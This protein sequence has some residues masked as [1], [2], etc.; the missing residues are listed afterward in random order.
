MKSDSL[1]VSVFI[2]T[3]S[4]AQAIELNKR[5][6]MGGSRPASSM[7]VQNATLKLDG[8]AW[9]TDNFYH[10]KEDEYRADTP[11]GY[12]HSIVYSGEPLNNSQVMAMKQADSLKNHQEGLYWANQSVH[13]NELHY[14]HSLAQ[15]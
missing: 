5:T 11:N 12:N 7:L 13:T 6:Q 14:E 9:T 1:I 10:M 4:L 3:L 2:G 8:V 15:A